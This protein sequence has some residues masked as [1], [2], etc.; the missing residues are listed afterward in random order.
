[1]SLQV[2][3]DI[4]DTIL[5][6]KSDLEIRD[7]RPRV[8]FI[9][10]SETAFRVETFLVNGVP[11][12]AYDIDT[13]LYA[14]GKIHSLQAYNTYT[15]NIPED[16]ISM[17][18]FKDMGEVAAAKAEVQCLAQNMKPNSIVF[19]IIP[20]TDDVLVYIRHTSY[21]EGTKPIIVETNN[22]HEIIQSRYPLYEDPRPMNTLRLKTLLALDPN[23]SLAYMEAQLDFL[24]SIVLSII[25]SNPDIKL[26][27]LDKVKE[28][29]NFKDAVE[30]SLVFT[31]KD[32]GKCL[33][34]IR[35]LKPFARKMQL[36]YYKGRQ[37]LLEPGGFN[38]GADAGIA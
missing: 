13:T 27:V 32:S 34:E 11:R 10:K 17:A 14:K 35:T 30:S 38:G 16:R 4:N 24:T 19:Y 2:F 21:I 25:E 33:E 7:K 9:K 23:E 26:H 31:V 29:A 37:K 3:M 18:I 1:M 28:Y 15:P 20:G 36:E 22:F 8:Y 6:N 5:T 12:A